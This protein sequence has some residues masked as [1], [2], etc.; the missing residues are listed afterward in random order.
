M[1]TANRTHLSLFGLCPISQ[2]PPVCPSLDSGY[3]DFG[4]KSHMI[5]LRWVLVTDLN[6]LYCYRKKYAS[7]RVTSVLWFVRERT[8]TRKPW[9]S[10]AVAA[11]VAYAPPTRVPA[12]QIYSTHLGR[13][14]V[15][16]VWSEMSGNLLRTN[17]LQPGE[18][19][20]GGCSNYM[21]Q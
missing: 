2:P 21:L 6:L 10:P 17:T 5:F 20:G 19:K 9:V 16:L 3:T 1:S 13:R 12:R 7:S 11:S 14:C 18:G 4:H 15:H 8:P